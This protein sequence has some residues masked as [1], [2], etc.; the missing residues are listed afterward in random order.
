M[1]LAWSPASYIVVSILAIGLTSAAIYFLY[2]SVLKERMNYKE[3]MANFIEGVLSKSEITSSINSYISKI[4][5]DSIF[6]IICFDIDKFSEVVS[7]FGE[8]E[9]KRIIDQIAKKILKVCPRTVT[10]GRNG[11]DTF[12]VYLKADATQSEVIKLANLI[13]STLNEPISVYG[14]TTYIP[15]VTIAVAF[16]PN[17]GSTSKQ[18]INSLRLALYIG[19]RDGGNKVVIYSEEMGQKETANL[20]YYT[21]VKEAIKNQEFVLYYQPIVDITNTKVYGMEGL[22]RWNHPELGVLSPFKFINILE[23]TGDINW[24]GIWGVETLIKKYFELKKDFPFMELQLSMNLSPKQLNDP[25][26]AVEFQ[27]LIKDYRINPKCITLEIVEFAIFE[28]LDVVRTNIQSLKELGFKIAVDGFALDQSTIS[29]L[30]NTP[31]DIIKL[32]REF[33]ASDEDSIIKERFASL[34]IEFAKEKNITIISEGVEDFEMLEFAKRHGIELVQGYY[35]S[36]PVTSDEIIE[37]IRDER[38]L[39][40]KCHHEVLMDA[41]KSD[42]QKETIENEVKSELLEDIVE[43]KEEEIVE[44]TEK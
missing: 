39:I 5:R 4:T 36:K 40:A 8:T 34:L 14:D 33:Y 29:R 44:K 21:Q 22:L 12:I 13:K 10:V 9:A 1:F 32:D 3:E 41:M 43:V 27:K 30:E 15:S 16:Y 20:E 6:G 11:L 42:I 25:K 18:L 7:A 38:G 2:R 23:Q 17:H 24:V 35:F 26:L 31:I 28:K 19:K 37:Y